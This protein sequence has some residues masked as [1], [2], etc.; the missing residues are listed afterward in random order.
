MTIPILKL[1]EYSTIRTFAR[2]LSQEQRSQDAVAKPVKID[3][4]EAMKEAKNRMRK[5][6]REK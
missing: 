1:F 5:R 6:I 2:Y 4:K 3:R